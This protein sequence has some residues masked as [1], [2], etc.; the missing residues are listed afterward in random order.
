[1]RNNWK[2]INIKSAVQK[3]KYIYIYIKTCEEKDWI[4]KV[5]K[6]IIIIATKTNK[7]C[8]LGH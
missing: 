3:K 5:K 4:E 1:M 2:Y 8:S 7:F 6:H